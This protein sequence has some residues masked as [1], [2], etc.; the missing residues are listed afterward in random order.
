MKLIAKIIITVLTVILLV[1]VYTWLLAAAVGLGVPETVVVV[2]KVIGTLALFIII[3]GIAFLA[4]WE[5]MR[6]WREW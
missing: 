3:G 4:V 2:A 6:M 5:L 1:V